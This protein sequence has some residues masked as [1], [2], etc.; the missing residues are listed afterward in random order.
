LRSLAE[1]RE[2]AAAIPGAELS[3]IDDTGHMI[4]IEAPQRL[5]DVIVPWLAAHAGG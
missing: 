2:M 5:V 1:A 3:V 4:P